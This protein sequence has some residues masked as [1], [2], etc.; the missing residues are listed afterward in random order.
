MITAAADPGAGFLQR[1][2]E[3]CEEMPDGLFARFSR[4]IYD[5]SGIHLPPHKKL[6]LAA[7]LTKRLRSLGISSFSEYYSLLSGLKSPD[8]E[9]THLI[10][11]VS[12]NKTEFYRESQ[13]FEYLRSHALP[14]I[15]ESGSFRDSGV[16]NIWSAGCSSGEEAY[17]AAIEV[18]DFLA[19]R[20]GRYRVLAT[21]ICTR[22]LEKGYRAVYPDGDLD[23]V[24]RRLMCRY[25]MKGV[26]EQAGRHRVVPEIR[27]RVAFMRHN[28]VRDDYGSLPPMDIIFCRNVA[29][30]F[31]RET[32][33]RT[34][35]R[36][37]DRLQPGGYIFIGHSEMMTDARAVLERVGPTIYR[38]RRVNP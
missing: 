36:L 14:A 19:G 22:V 6:M 28:L 13:H 23:A 2:Q 34:Y 5:E 25:F 15:V 4:I 21:D 37:I 20:T 35:G 3:S 38:K 1:P 31:D 27:S 30:Y 17:T 8:A 10:D 26:G 24:P 7:R 9:L 12:T 11:S 16:I 18:D 32:Q 29:I 33:I